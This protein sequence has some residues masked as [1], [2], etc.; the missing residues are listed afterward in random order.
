[1]MRTPRLAAFVLFAALAVPAVARAGADAAHYL[2]QF[3][4]RSADPRSDFF[5]YSVGKWL[6]ANPIPP[7]ERSWGI[8]HVV[9][10]ETYSR[11]VAINR[12]A[13]GSGAPK[14][15]NAQKIGDFWVAA[16]D[17]DGAAAAGMKPLAPEFARIAA[18]H[19]VPGVLESVAHLHYIGSRA[20]FGAFVSQDEMN[21]DRN[22]LHLWQGGLGLPNR[23]YYFDTDARSVMLRREYVKHVTRMFQL[24]GDAPAA[25]AAHARTVMTI[26][27]GL[28]KASRKLEDLRDPHANYNPMSL[29]E[30]GRL[31]PSIRWREFLEQGHIRDIDTVIVGQP[32]FFKAVQASLATHGV[33]GWKTYL[34]WHLANSFAEEA[35]GKYDAED[36]HFYGTILNGTPAQRPR[37]KRALDAEEN[38]LGDALGQLYVERYFTP[39]TKARYEKLTQD[40]F[41]AFR[42]RIQALAWM[43]DSTKTRAVHKLESVTR[44]VGYPSRW[45]DYST[46]DV[47][48]TS[49]L[50]NALRGNVWESEY[51]IAKLHKPVD[52][53]EW[54]MTPQT[55][56]AYYNPSNN[57]IV[58]PAAIFILPGIDDADVDDAIVYS[59]AGGTTIGH[60]ITHGFDD[61]GRQFDERG[62]LRDWWTAA[63]A[64]EFNQRAEAIVKQFDGYKVV[65]D[66]H[67][68][69]KATAGENIADLGG[70]LLGWDAFTKT[71]EYRKG[72]SIGGF[73][74]AQRYFIG[75][76]LGWMNQLR[77]E[78][79]AVRVK[80]DVHA[81]S[82]L[83]VTGPCSN[84]PAFYDA[85]GVKPGDPMYRS[86]ADR[87]R[88]W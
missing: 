74:P 60:E 76:S 54:D 55:Y 11:L 15:S 67:C 37:W 14:G 85:F 78:N 80:T 9:Q 46:Y 63:D 23:D 71:E 20:M 31:T 8:A 59:Y 12:E 79:L 66:L 5:R 77:P 6:A 25:A 36:F 40:I 43:S 10:E 28:A 73:T 1:M 18:I 33:A 21:S 38:Y 30:L 42:A 86:D 29:A 35:G 49:L 26:E 68:N 69:G 84:V 22:V 50:G 4:D 56:N 81:P 48:R 58:L 52:R 45:R 72:E 57:E 17:S 83:R 13:A 82:F 88:I 53:S 3:V 51:E 65:G 75:W 62:N 44:K 27:T 16:M 39:A 19:D 32:D 64:R 61:E 34:R 24:L 70:M 7:A 2:D 47:D 41:D 87:V